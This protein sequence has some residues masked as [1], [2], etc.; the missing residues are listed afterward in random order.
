MFKKIINKIKLYSLERRIKYLSKE[1]EKS[2]ER[3][4]D[5]KN[6]N[7]SLDAYCLIIKNFIN[8]NFDIN[9]LNQII[10]DADASDDYEN[11]LLDLADLIDEMIFY[12]K[13]ER[14][15]DECI[16]IRDYKN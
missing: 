14:D 9:D 3:I 4:E 11:D 1:I 16:N 15:I 7:S 8:K 12:M 13:L 2:K 10:N 6:N 5:I